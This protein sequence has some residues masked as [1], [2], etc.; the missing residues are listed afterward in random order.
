MG[1]FRIARNNV[2]RGPRCEEDPA[3]PGLL[4]LISHLKIAQRF[5]GERH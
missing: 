4:A 3:L 2:Q 5:S 1:T